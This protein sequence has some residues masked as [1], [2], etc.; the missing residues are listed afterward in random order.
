MQILPILIS[1]QDVRLYF[2]STTRRGSANL[3]QGG[4]KAINAFEKPYKVEAVMA[5][6]PLK[7]I[8]SQEQ[9]RQSNQNASKS[10][11]EIFFGDALEDA[12]TA[13]VEQDRP[14]RHINIQTYGYTRDGLPYDTFIKMRE[15]K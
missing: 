15:Y 13:A 10:F 11:A 9:N 4:I 6:T 1:E 3:I 5:V 12:K 8:S 7:K 2:L 14:I